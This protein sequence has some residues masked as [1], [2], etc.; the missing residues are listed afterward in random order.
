MIPGP[1]DALFHGRRRRFLALQRADGADALTV[2]PR[3]PVMIPGP[4]NA[5]TVI[6]QGPMM[7]PGVSDAI[8]T[9]NRV[10]SAAL[11]SVLRS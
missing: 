1:S 10:G 11:N 5:P 2:I 9:V 7:I 4:S 8:V 3:A 6:P